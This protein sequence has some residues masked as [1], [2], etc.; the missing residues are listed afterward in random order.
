[1]LDIEF[2]G[3]AWTINLPFL[4]RNHFL[5]L[6]QSVLNL[7]L[8]W[9]SCPRIRHHIKYL[10]TR[11][12]CFTLR[13]PNFMSHVTLLL[14]KFCCPWQMEVICLWMVIVFMC[15]LIFSKQALF[16][17]GLHMCTKVLRFSF[18]WLLCGSLLSISHLYEVGLFTGDIPVR[19]MTH[20]WYEGRALG[21]FL[22]F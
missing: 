4:W 8:W 2:D 10:Q 18:C 22:I 14:V 5:S 21:V 13:V 1:M 9:K 15:S 3:L 16:I 6:S 19:N 12:L 11:N 17:A 20:L 7:N